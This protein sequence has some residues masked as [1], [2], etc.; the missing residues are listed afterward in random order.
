MLLTF[1]SVSLVNQKPNG[2]VRFDAEIRFKR[3]RPSIEQRLTDQPEKRRRWPWK[4]RRQRRAASGAATND[5][6]ERPELPLHAAALLQ[7]QRR[8]FVPPKGDGRV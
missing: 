5:A 2:S 4:S 6:I 8:L 7:G 1:S 3:R